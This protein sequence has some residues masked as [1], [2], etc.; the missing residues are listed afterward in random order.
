MSATAVLFVFASSFAFGFSSSHKC[1]VQSSQ[2]NVLR[3]LSD[4]IQSANRVSLECAEA[5]VFEPLFSAYRRQS[6]AKSLCQKSA[7]CLEFLRSEARRI[8][9][10]SG[11][12]FSEKSA[13]E[14]WGEILMHSGRTRKAPPKLSDLPLEKNPE[15]IYDELR[16]EAEADTTLNKDDKL[17]LA[18]SVLVGM[19]GPGKFK[20]L[21]ALKV[22]PKIQ[23]I[24]MSH[25]IEKL[26]S[27]NRLPPQVKEKFLKWSQDVETKGL[28]ETKKIPGYHDEPLAGFPGW[29]S[30]RLNG[31]FRACYEIIEKGGAQLLRVFSIS[32]DHKNY[33]R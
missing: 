3:G 16:N 21:L 17:K 14:L 8:A 26:I 2:L 10:G 12:N 24:E 11:S 32:N 31:G 7:P 23:K 15:E 1:E 28:Q 19:L 20:P 30:V 4:R 18:C 6:L 27:K 25:D 33:C 29:H 13:V 5:E 22:A 9:Q